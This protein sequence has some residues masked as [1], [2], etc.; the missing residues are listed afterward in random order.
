MAVAECGCGGALEVGDD[1]L[2]QALSCPFCS[3]VVRAVASAAATQPFTSRLTITAGPD[4]VGEQFL[5]GGDGAIGLG[6]LATNLIRFATPLVSRN[7]CELRRT[8][9]GGWEIADRNS[10]NGLFV[11]KL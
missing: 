10:T 7:H 8:P 6:K 9:A 1:A 2:G 4:R 5:L 11:N 3:S